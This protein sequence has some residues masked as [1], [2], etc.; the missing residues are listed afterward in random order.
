MSPS[1]FEVRPFFALE[2]PEAEQIAWH[3]CGTEL[4]NEAFPDETRTSLET[5]RR[6]WRH[7]PSFQRHQ[8]W[9][10]WLPDG[11]AVVAQ[12]DFHTWHLG[13]NQ[14]AGSIYIGV[15]PEYR[16][17]GLAR[18][19]LTFLV[20]AARSEDRH[21]L[22]AD[23]VSSAPAAEGFLEHLGARVGTTQWCN[24]LSIPEIG[25]DRL[26]AL[27]AAW[28]QRGQGFELGWWI[29]PYPEEALEEVVAMKDA[30]NLMPRDDLELVD[31]HLTVEQVRAWEK[32]VKAGP[33]ERWT[34]Y[35]RDPETGRIAGYTQV[36][37][38]PEKPDKVVQDDTAVFREYQNRGLGRLLKGVMLEKILRERPQVTRIQTWNAQSNGP[39]LKINTEM[40]FRPHHVSKGWQ[41]ETE[42]LERY[43]QGA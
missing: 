10:V 24:Q 3:H 1:E 15:L 5:V 21:L 35:A 37:W 29:G 7:T 6:H 39:M 27:V 11:S 25:R 8:R 28:K 20:E 40:G 9:A 38:M 4:A 30:T 31:D 43:L 26:E 34:L 14:H 16:G 23:T 22:F 41:V 2:A 17:R 36:W 42:R 33:D 19:L 18:R 32:G 13:E 12:A